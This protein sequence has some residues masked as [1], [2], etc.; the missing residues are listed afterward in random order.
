[1]P[2]ESAPGVPLVDVQA[3]TQFTWVRF[4]PNQIV[5]E[6]EVEVLAGS[7]G[8]KEEA[9]ERAQMQGAVR[10]LLEI[11]SQ[12]ILLEAAVVNPQN[13][14]KMMMESFGT[15]KINRIWQNP[16]PLP[17]GMV[18]AS[19]RPKPQNEQTSVAD[20]MKSVIQTA[21]PGMGST[22]GGGGEMINPDAIN[23]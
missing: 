19:V 15:N 23:R 17:E 5:D 11:A 4:T 13:L 12:A 3:G 8:A 20:M 10:T 1:M 2:A 14:S 21:E 6:A 9:L 22:A 16:K 18:P 7:M